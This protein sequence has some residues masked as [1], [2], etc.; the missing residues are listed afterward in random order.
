MDYDLWSQCFAVVA[1]EFLRVI[2]IGLTPE[3]NDGFVRIVAMQH[4]SISGLLCEQKRGQT[5]EF[6]LTDDTWNTFGSTVP[7]IN[8][9]DPFTLLQASI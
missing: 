2:I 5:M 8:R 1:S 4:E 7:G 3:W 6:G 9:Y